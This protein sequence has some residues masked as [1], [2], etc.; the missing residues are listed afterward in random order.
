MCQVMSGTGCNSTSIRKGE[1]V[2]TPA[3]KSSYVFLFFQ[4]IIKQVEN[5]WVPKAEEV[6]LL[7]SSLVSANGNTLK[8]PLLLVV[9][10]GSAGNLLVDMCSK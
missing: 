5:K 9:E 6:L 7:S 3:K 1:V 4:Q 8:R 10:G 2:M